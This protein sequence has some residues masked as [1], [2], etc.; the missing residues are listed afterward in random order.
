M[1]FVTLHSYIANAAWCI[2]QFIMLKL[3]PLFSSS[4]CWDLRTQIL[5]TSTQSKKKQSDDEIGWKQIYPYYLNYFIWRSIWKW[6]IWN[7]ANNP[8]LHRNSVHNTTVSTTGS[9]YTNYEGCLQQTVWGVI[10]QFLLTVSVCC[11]WV[12]LT[13]VFI[14]I[15]FQGLSH[16]HVQCYYCSQEWRPEQTYDQSRNTKTEFF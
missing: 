1:F 16:Y 14:V 12:L 11:K 6:A 7:A 4:Y 5:V 2:I 3:M 10:L 13:W 15:V 9:V 8:T